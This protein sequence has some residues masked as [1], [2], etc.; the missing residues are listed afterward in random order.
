MTDIMDVLKRSDLMSRVKSSDTEP[1]LRVRRLLH[2]LGYRF[3]LHPSNLPGKPDIVLPRYRTA[4]FVHGCFWHSHRGC[5]AAKRPQSNMD[6][7]NGKLD[8]N[9]ARDKRKAQQLRARGWR[10][11]VVWE[12]EV[13]ARKK[14]PPKLTSLLTGEPNGSYGS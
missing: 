13:S 12:C 9:M 6:F 11:V 8:A 3:R 1:E 14:L 10:V 7:W 5:A 4:I 2:A